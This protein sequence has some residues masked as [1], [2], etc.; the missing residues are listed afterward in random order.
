MEVSRVGGTTKGEELRLLNEE[1]MRKTTSWN[2]KVKRKIVW[3][4]KRLVEKFLERE[5]SIVKVQEGG[6]EVVQATG[7]RK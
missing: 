7:D 4:V 2:M 1:M 6:C 5:P 3:L